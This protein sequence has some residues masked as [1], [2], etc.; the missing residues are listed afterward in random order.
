MRILFEEHFHL[1]NQL[2]DAIK[3][4][5]VTN[6]CLNGIKLGILQ[7]RLHGVK[8]NSTNLK[9]YTLST[10]MEQPDQLYTVVIRGGG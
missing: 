7:D 5:K 10:N 4:A 8:D 2:L 3:L 6:P 9:F 1:Y